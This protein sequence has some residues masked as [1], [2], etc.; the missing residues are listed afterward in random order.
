MII[1]GSFDGVIKKV[2]MWKIKGYG[3]YFWVCRGFVM[4]V[5]RGCGKIGGV[6]VKLFL[7]A[8]TSYPDI[9]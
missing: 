5:R 9:C 2:K 3:A 6:E 1:S 4:I 8:S 7:I